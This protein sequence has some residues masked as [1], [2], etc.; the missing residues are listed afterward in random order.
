MANQILAGLAMPGGELVAGMG[1]YVVVG[2]GACDIAN[3][4]AETTRLDVGRWSG[5]FI[6]REVEVTH[7]G[8]FGGVA[9][10]RVGYDWL[11]RIEVSYDVTAPPDIVLNNVASVGLILN[12][13]DPEA[14]QTSLV[15]RYALPSGLL[16]EVETVDDARAVDIVRQTATVKG[17]SVF[18]L[19]PNEN[20]V[21]AAYIAAL[22]N[23]GWLG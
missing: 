18:F 13:G 8:C 12:L 7:S 10:R 16:S 11:A 5:R 23:R 6:Y 9:R 3:L 2:E 4:S 21:Y 17:N 14:Y 20:A 1:G 19:L 22:Q 15:K